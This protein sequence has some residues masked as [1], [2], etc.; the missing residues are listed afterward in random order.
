MPEEKPTSVFKDGSV[1]VTVIPKEYERDGEVCSFE[2]YKVQRRFLNT[3]GNW[4]STCYFS[5]R[6]LVK[7]HGILSNI[8]KGDLN[9]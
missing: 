7:L 1:E 5:H 4:D 3:K 8:L 2:N 6:D 9:G